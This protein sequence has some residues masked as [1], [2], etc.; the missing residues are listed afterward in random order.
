MSF[1]Q[2]E[3][4]QL[5]A[6]MERSLRH[7]WQPPHHQDKASRVPLMSQF[8]HHWRRL[9][10]AFTKGANPLPVCT[11][12]PPLSPQNPRFSWDL[13][14]LGIKRLGGDPRTDKPGI[15]W[16]FYISRGNDGIN[17]G[18]VHLV[19]WKIEARRV[20]SNTIIWKL[21]K[22]VFMKHR[23]NSIH[24]D[25]QKKIDKAEKRFVMWCVNRLIGKDVGMCSVKW[26]AVGGEEAQVQIKNKSIKSGEGSW[27]ATSADPTSSNKIQMLFARCS[28]KH[29][30]SGSFHT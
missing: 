24:S 9:W 18:K 5:L 12:T 7:L 4:S 20:S 1:S 16:L 10:R 6:D 17:L 26:P 30:L 23:R 27:R 8:L 29:K 19:K 2:E 13:P 11:Q 25:Y 22:W 3:T 28:I 14:S 21:G 15:S